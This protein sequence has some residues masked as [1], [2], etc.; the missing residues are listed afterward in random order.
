MIIKSSADL[1]KIKKQEIEKQ[2]KYKSRIFVGMSSC[3]VA[4]GAKEILGK[5][6]QVLSDKG[7]NDVEVVA[8]GCVGYCYTEPTVEVIRNDGS[9]LLL[10]PVRSEDVVNV[11]DMHVANNLTESKYVLNKTYSSCFVK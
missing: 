4:A 3:G 5:F 8:T 11:V 9:S 10:G 2:Q 7:I 1:E 6:K